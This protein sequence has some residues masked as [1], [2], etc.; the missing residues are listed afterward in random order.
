MDYPFL[1]LLV[2]DLLEASVLAALSEC[3]K[4]VLINSQ[5]ILIP[6]ESFSKP[7]RSHQRDKVY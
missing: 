5:Y 3:D 6:V 7:M 2:D 1:S 4:G